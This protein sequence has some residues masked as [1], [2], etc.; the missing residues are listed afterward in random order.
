M[1]RNIEYTE[2]ALIEQP[3]IDLFQSLE[4]E[5]VNAFHEFDS[6]ASTLGRA[7]MGEV[8]LL[9]RLRESL[10]RFNPGIPADVLEKAIEELTLDRSA[11]T[12][13]QAN[14]Q[15]YELIKNGVTVTFNDPLTGK[16]RSER[17]KV[18]DWNN[19]KNND[20]L[21]VSQFWIMGEMY[22]RRADLIGFVNGLPLVFIE[23]KTSHV[24][25]K[26]AYDDN[27]RDYKETIPHLFWYNA[28]IILSNG[29][30]SRIGSITAEWEHFAEWKKI[31]DEGEEGIISLET[32]I[33]GTCDPARLLDIVEN[34]VLFKEVRGTIKL[35]AMNH[36]YLG[37]NNV[38]ARLMKIKGIEDRLPDFVPEVKADGSSRL[39][40]RELVM[41]ENEAE[42]R[43]ADEPLTRGRLGVYWHTQGSGKSVSMIFFAQKVLRK[44]PGNWSFV[45]VT[46]RDELDS[47]IYK[48]FA[49]AGVVTED[50]VQAE[51][52]A[53]LRQLL[54]EDHRYIFTLIHK[55]R[56]EKGTI[57]PKISDRDDIIVI[58][59]EAHRSQYDTLA[60]NMRAAL[61]NAMFIAFTG[62]PLIV[63]E[64]EKTRDTFG[65]YVSIY[66]FQQSIDDGATVPL[67]YENRIP[68]LQL[69]NENLN[70]DIYKA[71]EDA[72]LDEA[73][74][75]KLEK[76]LGKQYHILT[77]DDRLEAVAKDLVLHFMGRGFKGKAMVISIDKATTLRLY[78]KVQA[79]WKVYLDGLKVQLAGADEA[80]KPKIQAAID[81][82]SQT[83]MAVV[84]S[85]GQNEISDMRK[86]GLNIAPHRRRMV[87]EDLE[88]KFK[89]P[90]DPF[91]IVFVCA[92]WI[93]GFDVPH[94]STIY[95]DKPLR[96]HTLMQTIARA[97]RVFPEKNNGLIVDYVGV[98]RSLQKALAIYGVVST[99]GGGELPVKD[100]QAL[101]AMLV[102]SINETK[103]YCAERRVSIDAIKAA[104]GFARIKLIDDAYERIVTND[105]NRDDYLRHAGHVTK[106]FKAILPDPEANHLVPDCVAIDVIAKKIRSEMPQPDISAIMGTIEGIL[107]SSIT[108]EG[109]RIEADPN[110]ETAKSRYL[111]L[112]KIDFEK[113]AQMFK[114]GKKRLVIERLRRMIEC[115]LQF[116]IQMNRMRKNYEDEFNKLIEEY[117]AGSRN[118]QETYDALR[119]YMDKLTE[120]ECRHIREQLSEEELTIFDLLT[121][122]EMDLT[123]SEQKQVKQ[124]ARDLLEKLKQEK[125][126]LDWRKR[127]DSRAAVLVAIQDTLE[128]LPTVFTKAMY[129]RKCDTVFQ[130]V[131]ES[132]F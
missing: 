95:L 77:R 28:F 118:V 64:E 78:D 127:Q 26:H 49:S 119:K 37:V 18:I 109:F 1:M 9:N 58:T 113:L 98:F 11:M 70:D 67:Y 102:E 86:K 54:R 13:V 87:N 126:S 27:L 43:K 15:V 72:E 47:Q 108:A 29:S 44:L 94:C 38:I 33:R 128:R 115:K 3:A 32:M 36:Q 39:A 74:E 76:A 59:D 90:D 107:D 91:R 6:A 16:E 35:V 97:N 104:N 80:D 55:F 100:K 96:N 50:E 89:D 34:F 2:D 68:E 31:N 121:K 75:E 88:T 71:I 130:H 82:M 131:C 57:H 106:I 73:Q 62:T 30:K 93:T 81:Y 125:F 110:E 120:E 41:R 111:D 122:P 52:S 7:D 23:L 117:N 12:M 69:I 61:K 42:Y 46:D 20:F 83:D 124:V 123:D 53:H 40:R 85:Q 79:Q 132:N 60:G 112:S 8:V 48:E 66:N 19:P 17:V 101:V 45:I 129:D 14:R 92:M 22:K 63:G 4:W 21:L 56:T 116:M 99:D 10:I 25:L 84:V 5:H 103:A 51:S 105:E 24:S 114:Q 65:D